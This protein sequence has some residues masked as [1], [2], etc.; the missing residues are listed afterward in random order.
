MALQ[1]GWPCAQDFTAPK[2]HP[3]VSVAQATLWQ[4]GQGSFQVLHESVQIYALKVSANPAVVQSNAVLPVCA[5]GIVRARPEVG[6]NPYFEPMNVRALAP[7]D[8]QT[9]PSHCPIPVS[10]R[11]R[12]LR[13]HVQCERG[14][15]VFA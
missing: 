5:S 14:S 1:H 9:Q 3:I 11:C 2:L 10:V 15:M 4:A 6:N 7:R 8:Q 12:L 13:S